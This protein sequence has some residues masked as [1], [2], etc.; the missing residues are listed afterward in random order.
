MVSDLEI[1]ILS[2]PNNGARPGSV[3]AR[4]K[5]SFRMKQENPNRSAARGAPRR[6]RGF[7]TAR[8]PS[9]SETARA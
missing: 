6:G 3:T 8:H 2:T 1:E 7:K 5:S 4:A 9:V